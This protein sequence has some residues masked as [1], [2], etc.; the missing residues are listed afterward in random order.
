MIK[1]FI[2][3]LL[4]ILLTNYSFG[5]VFKNSSGKGIFFTEKAKQFTVETTASEKTTKFDFKFNTLLNKKGKDWSTSYYKLADLNNDGKKED[6]ERLKTVQTSVGL[7]FKLG[8]ENETSLVNNLNHPAISFQFGIIKSVD[9]LNQNNFASGAP[10]PFSFGL[11][12]S[13]KYDNKKT[14]YDTNSETFSTEHPYSF[15]VDGHTELFFRNINWFTLGFTGGFVN[16]TNYGDLTSFQLIDSEVIIDNNITSLS[17]KP[18]GKI[19]DLDRVNNFYFSAS[20]PLFPFSKK[21]TRNIANS[22]IEKIGFTPFY[23][24]TFG[25]SKTDNAG[26]LISFVNKSFRNNEYS[27]LFDGSFN[28]G[29]DWAKKSG[30]WGKPVYFIGGTLSI[31]GIIKGSRPVDEDK[32]NR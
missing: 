12:V 4:V 21:E 25:D 9:S 20:L 27:S 14:L 7:T 10:I 13:G 28:F 30:N 18:D 16:T 2:L 17:S 22:V 5:Q 8:I 23:Y 31:D 29:V 6:T 32:S 26:C 11:T 3:L 15:S 24:G 19:G 1:N